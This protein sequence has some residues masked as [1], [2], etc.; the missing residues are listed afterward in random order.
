MNDSFTLPTI[1]AIEDV[2]LPLKIVL[3]EIKATIE[4][5]PSTPKF[6]RNNYLKEIFGLSDNTIVQYRN[7]NKIPYTFIGDVYFYPVDEINK[8]LISNSNFKMTKLP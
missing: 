6:Y 1:K 4:Q 8:I 2:I 5:K 7:T 3:N